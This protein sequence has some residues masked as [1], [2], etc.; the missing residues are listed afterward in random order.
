ML[1]VEGPDGSGKTTLAK[2]ISEE[3]GIEYRRAPSLSSVDGPDLAVYDWWRQQVN[4][5]DTA[6]YDRTFFISELIY[7][8]ASRDRELIV[9]PKMMMDGMTDMW[10]KGVYWIFCSPAWDTTLQIIRSQPEKLKGVTERDLQKIHW[11]YRVVGNLVDLASPVGHV[12]KHDFT[13]EPSWDDQ[14]TEFVLYWV[15]TSYLEGRTK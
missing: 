15:K 10:I 2:K 6:V 14:A 12:Y 4:A 7:Q 3:F 11:A 1:I 9:T 13:A 5:N 8:L